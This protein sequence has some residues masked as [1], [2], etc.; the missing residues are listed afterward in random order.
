MI[1][2]AAATG[3]IEAI[4]STGGNPDPILHSVGL[5]R[6]IISD[7]EQFIPSATFARLL[8]ECARCTGDDCFGLHF[9]ERYN[10][11]NIGALV[12]VVLNSPTMAAAVENAARYMRL[13]NEAAKIDSSI[14]DSLFH[15]RVRLVRL[16]LRA[17]RQLHEYSMALALNT[18]RML[19]GT[20]WNPREVQ[21]AHEAPRDSSE[22]VRV[23]HAPVSFGCPANA[24]VID[25]EFIE[26]QVPAANPRLYKVLKKFL[27][28]VLN[29]MP[30]ENGLLATVRKAI[31]ELMRDGAPKLARV[32]AKMAV[33]PRT[34]QRQLSEYG[35]DFKELVDNTRRLSAINYLRNSTNTLTEI[36][37]LLGYSEL[38]AFNRAFKRWT[39]S[40]PL[41]FRRRLAH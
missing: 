37:F 11:E 18:I 27:D 30:A 41:N 5:S 2:L 21:F 25:R 40:T 20:R 36:A 14:E 29:Q 22:H 9:G 7:E 32:A 39:G 38:S 6:A 31:A 34:L 19:A 26:R 16:R 8:E 10:P 4:A 13:Y 24:F 35:V 28:H 33:S 3:I 1:S 12:Y 23:F 17:P 15:I